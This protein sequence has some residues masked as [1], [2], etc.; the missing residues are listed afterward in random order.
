MEVV[1]LDAPAYRMTSNRGITPLNR[2]IQGS[3]GNVRVSKDNS[4]SMK[5][6]RESPGVRYG[7][8]SGYV[9]Y[10]G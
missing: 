5:S 1:D 9:P 6:Y 8:Y 10:Y 3:L 7:G 4:G 2:R